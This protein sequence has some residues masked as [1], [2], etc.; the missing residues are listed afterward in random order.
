MTVSEPWRRTRR[1]VGGLAAFILV[2]IGGFLFAA[3]YFST[4]AS[5]RLTASG[6]PSPVAALFVSGDAGLHFGMGPPTVK[7]LAAHGVTVIGFNS[8]TLF[9]FHRSRAET[10]GLVADMV[11]QTVRETGHDRLVLIGQSYGADVLQTGLAALPAE[12]RRHVAAIVL[13][14]P[15]DAVYFRADASGFAYR[16]APDSDGRTTLRSLT[17]A[18][19]TCIYG[20]AETDSACP[21]LKLANATVIGMPGGH[22][23]GHDADGLTALVLAAVRR[24]AGN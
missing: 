2:A 22:F 6:D 4:E 18:P 15:G 13:V 17:W 16:A 10:N 23:L 8:P 9:R 20:R 24:A 14:V 7:A 3:G 19:V 5:E 1:W 21:G 12:L 11:R